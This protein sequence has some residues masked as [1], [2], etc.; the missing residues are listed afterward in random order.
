VL[1]CFLSK[2]AATVCCVV[3]KESDIPARNGCC[4]STHSAL[5]NVST[6]K[7]P[8]SLI[9]FELHFK[10]AVLDGLSLGCGW[11]DGLQL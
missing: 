9:N 6:Y 1:V 5:Q 3:E 4:V 7:L 8:V 2:V 11:R 10:V